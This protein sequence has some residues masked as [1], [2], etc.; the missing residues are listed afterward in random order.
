MADNKTCTGDY[1][2]CTFQQQTYCAAQRTYAIMENQ[3][4]IVER[5]ERIEAA[6]GEITTGNNI[7]NPLKEDIAQIPG[8]AENRPESSI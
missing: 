2:K 5:L 1:L 4:V 3:R 8:G 6:V 7:I